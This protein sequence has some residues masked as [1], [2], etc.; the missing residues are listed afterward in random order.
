MEGLHLP[1]KVLI[2]RLD[3]SGECRSVCRCGK[4]LGWNYSQE[5]PQLDSIMH[6]YKHSSPFHN[7]HG[8]GSKHLYH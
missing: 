2:N 3:G 1:V 6:L 5:C 7:D 4:N 8:L